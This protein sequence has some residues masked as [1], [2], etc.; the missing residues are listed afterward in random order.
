MMRNA[1]GLVVKGRVMMLR[2]AFGV[3]IENENKKFNR[4]PA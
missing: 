3:E 4:N 2:N 1:G